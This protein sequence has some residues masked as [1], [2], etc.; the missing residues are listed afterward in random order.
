MQQATSPTTKERVK[1]SAGRRDAVE[2]VTSQDRNVPQH[3]QPQRNPA[4]DAHH[5]N[6]KKRDLPPAI[7]APHQTS[8]RKNQ[9][10]TNQRNGEGEGD[11]DGERTGEGEGAGEGESDDEGAGETEGEGEGEGEGAGAGAG[12]GEG[13][14]RG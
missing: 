14:E 3:I 13:A 7:Q 11:G 8:E 9:A 1:A 4:Q 5:K 6:A 2:K 10:D 12:A